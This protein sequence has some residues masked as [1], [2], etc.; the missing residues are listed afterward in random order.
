MTLQIESLCRILCIISLTRVAKRRRKQ[1][2]TFDHMPA[3]QCAL[4][5]AGRADSHSGLW[6]ALERITLAGI[7]DE[8]PVSATFT[9]SAESICCLHTI[10]LVWT[11]R[12][13]LTEQPLHSVIVHLNT[14]V[15]V[16][17]SSFRICCV[18]TCCYKHRIRTIYIS[19]LSEF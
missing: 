17:E 15:Y 4:P 13:Q 6:H 10:R 8:H 9:V 3:V 7:G 14:Y 11:P 18:R 16:C 12:P 1:P 2:L 19:V 5:S